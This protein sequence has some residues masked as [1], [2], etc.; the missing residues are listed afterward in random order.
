[1]RTAFKE[2]AHLVDALGRGEQ[3]LSR[4]WVQLDRRVVTTGARL[5]LDQRTFDHQLNQ[6][7]A[8]LIPGA[9]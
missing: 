3:I 4:S 2:W 5:V 1:M 8:A 7:L 9:A 6:F